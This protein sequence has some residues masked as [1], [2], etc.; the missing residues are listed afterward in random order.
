MDQNQAQPQPNQV[1]QVTPKISLE[2]VHLKVRNRMKILFEGDAKAVT[3][4]N[5]TGRFD[6]LPGHANFISVLNKEI[7]VHKIDG[8]KESITLQNG[9]MKVKQGEIHCYLDLLTATPEA[10]STQQPQKPA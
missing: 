5:D 4:F 7:I 9:V 6:I 1:P 10:N 3:S 8:T 2:K